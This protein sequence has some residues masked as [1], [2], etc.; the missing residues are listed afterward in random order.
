MRIEEVRNISTENLLQELEGAHR[1][2]FN[3]RFQKAMQQLS[4]AT[5][6]RKTRKT[7]ARIRTV[8]R[9]R[10]LAEEAQAAAQTEAGTR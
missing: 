2:L 7:V 9:E 3:L 5:A 10:Q 8:L 4:D 6:I 1:E